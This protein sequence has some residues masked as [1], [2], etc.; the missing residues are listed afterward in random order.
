MVLLNREN[1]F[2]GNPF[3]DRSDVIA[4]L[5][6]LLDPLAPHTSPGG[7][8]ITLGSSGT[9]YDLRAC[10]LEAFARPLWGLV[11]L[12]A[13]GEKYERT[14][15]WMRG[16]ASGTDPESKEYWGASKGKDQRMVETSPIGFA[17]VMAHEQL[18]DVSRSH[19]RLWHSGLTPFIASERPGKEERGSMARRHQRQAYA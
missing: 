15:T 2:P 8:L 17:L 4:G 14:E 19:C 11:S 18:F 1:G 7:A 5:K 13:G 12:L 3:R 10:Q 16:L 9:H 6:G